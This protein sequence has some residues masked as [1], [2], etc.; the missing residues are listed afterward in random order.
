MK[1]LGCTLELAAHQ[2]SYPLLMS[3]PLAGYHPMGLGMAVADI[4]LILLSDLNPFGLVASLQPNLAH[5]TSPTG[6]RDSGPESSINGS[7]IR[8]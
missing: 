2:G 4:M 1:L 5:L 8:R 6:V 7:G 3:T